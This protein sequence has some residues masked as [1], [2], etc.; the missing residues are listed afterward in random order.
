MSVSHIAMA[1]A[2][3]RGGGCK[4]ASSSSS[5]SGGEWPTAG[6]GRGLRR[7]LEWNRNRRRAADSSK[8][9]DTLAV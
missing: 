8:E 6:L 9:R 1:T 2:A 3:Y 4:A 5:S 7:C